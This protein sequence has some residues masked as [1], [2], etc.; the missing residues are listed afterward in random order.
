GPA[1]PRHR[2]RPAGRRAARGKVKTG[3]KVPDY[4]RP[5]ALNSGLLRPFE[6]GTKRDNKS[7]DSDST[8]CVKGH[9]WKRP[10]RPSIAA[11]GAHKRRG[12]PGTKEVFAMRRHIVRALVALAA[13]GTA[14]L[15]AGLTATSAA[16]QTAG[17][18]AASYPTTATSS[19]A[20]YMDS[21]R[22][23]RFVGTTV[24]VP[25]P[26]DYDHYAQ[27]RLRGQNVAGVNLAIKPGGQVG[28]AVGAAPFGR[29]GG[30][31]DIGAK[32][33][34]TVRIDLYYDKT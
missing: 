18:H 8:A 21:G 12:E 30:T 15:T 33:G 10:G 13:G 19:R 27:V 9:F 26:G 24:K 25:A 6:S 11:P 22:W 16:A 7:K 32:A 29:G 4:S 23:F 3:E 17:T 20:G 28:W 5:M 34:D 14:L 2:G 1:V 31:L